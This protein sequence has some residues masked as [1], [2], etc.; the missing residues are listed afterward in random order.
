MHT[1]V[2]Q[3]HRCLHLLGWSVGESSFVGPDG[4][5]FWQVDATRAFDTQ[6][7]VV[8]APSQTGAWTAA[9]R[10]AGKIEQDRST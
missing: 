5:R 1:P 9:C 8:R 6:T 2:D 4:S 3:A 7:I 10:M